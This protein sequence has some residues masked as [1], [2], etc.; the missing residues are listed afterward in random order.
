MN[1]FA[2]EWEEAVERKNIPVDNS[3]IIRKYFVYLIIIFYLELVQDDATGL[4]G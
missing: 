3:R 2:D 1:R 4:Q